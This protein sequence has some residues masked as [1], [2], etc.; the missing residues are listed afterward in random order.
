M[1]WFNLLKGL[2]I[3]GFIVAGTSW[4][5]KK[6]LEKLLDKDLEKF[7]ANL[8]KNAIEFKIR[9]EKLQGERVEVIK[10]VYKKI[11]GVHISLYTLIISG[12]PQ[13]GESGEE[14]EKRA[15]IVK[16]NMDDL[17]KYYG[18]NRIF[19][20]EEMAKD[21]DS[22]VDIFLKARAN[23]IAAGVSGMLRDPKTRYSQWLESWELIDKKTPKIKGQ[24]EN[25]FRTILG[26]NYEK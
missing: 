25:K 14:T 18:E 4:L 15:E 23:F 6:Y 5:I 21:A 24:L 22:L 19:F 13:T 16:N 1:D 11:V 8:E 3:F 7:K 9:Y 17:R 2:G 12:P 20:E 10:E 26:I